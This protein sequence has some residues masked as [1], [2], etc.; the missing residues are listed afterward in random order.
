MALPIFD[1]LEEGALRI[2]YMP[3]SGDTLVVSF[4]GV[5]QQRDAEPEL[6]FVGNASDGGKNHVLFVT[7]ESRCWLNTPGMAERV[8]HAIEQTQL[9]FDIKR[10]VGLGNSMGGSMALII[11][12][13]FAFDAV[14]AIVPQFSVDPEIVP[15]E[16]RWKYFR[17]QITEFRFP[18]VSDLRPEHTEYFIVH[19]GHFKEHPHVLRF[20]EQRGVGHYVLP[21]R[22]HRMALQLKAEDTLDTL[23]RLGLAGARGRFRKHI[24]GLGGQFRSTFVSN[25]KMAEDTATQ[26]TK[27]T[28]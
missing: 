5:G 9:E 27:D 12:R 26:K 24:F 20:E 19:G 8:V 4:S 11:S 10:V 16:R 22:G 14:L 28:A 15:D 25:L 7:D 1:V 21:E 3:G 13:M 2:R 6:E 17:N 23:I 18:K